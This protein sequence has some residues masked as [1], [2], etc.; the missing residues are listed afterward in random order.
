MVILRELPYKSA[1]FGLVKWVTESCW[2]SQWMRSLTKW[3]KPSWRYCRMKNNVGFWWRFFI[4]NWPVLS[5]EQMSK[6]WPN[7]PLLND[8]QIWAT[9]WGLGTCQ[10][11]DCNR[12]SQFKLGKCGWY[13]FHTIVIQL[14]PLHF[15]DVEFMDCVPL[16]ALSKRRL[17][18]SI[19][20]LPG[21]WTCLRTLISPSI[22]RFFYRLYDIQM[23]TEKKYRKNLC[24]YKSI[25]YIHIYEHIKHA[26]DTWHKTVFSELFWW[27]WGLD[28]AKVQRSIV[29]PVSW[30]WFV[31]VISSWDS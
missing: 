1:L 10:L 18:R 23:K 5:D 17:T 24:A 4:F 20:L 9:G 8:E 31:D 6:R 11:K 16:L 14:S 19:T 28:Q 13:N 30:R 7:F 27:V 3:W 22:R 25:E 26:L 29:T 12:K 15:A 21:P 2:W